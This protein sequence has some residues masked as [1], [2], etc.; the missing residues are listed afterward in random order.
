[1]YIYTCT[2]IYTYIYNILYI[3]GYIYIY[4]CIYLCMLCNLAL[5]GLY[6]LYRAIVDQRKKKSSHLHIYI[7][8]YFACA[9]CSIL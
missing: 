7:H 1:M 4:V 8:K 5:I 3:Y 9:F 6:F 2:Y